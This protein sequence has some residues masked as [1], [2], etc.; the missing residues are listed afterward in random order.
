MTGLVPCV[1]TTVVV[2]G[3]WSVSRS[4]KLAD[5]IEEVVDEALPGTTTVVHIEPGPESA[6]ASGVEQGP[7]AASASGDASGTE[8]TPAAR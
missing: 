6:P 3:D 4:H 1:Q 7:D 8:G 2:P 5:R